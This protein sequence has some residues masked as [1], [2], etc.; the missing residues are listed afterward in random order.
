MAAARIAIQ[1]PEWRGYTVVMEVHFTPEQQA[2]L[3][4]LAGRMGK[5]AEQVVQETVARMLDEDARF[6]EAVAQGFASLDRGEYVEDE[7]VEARIRR[8]LKA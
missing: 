4:D 2:R 3:A 7:E 5:N 6:S 8:L 1:K